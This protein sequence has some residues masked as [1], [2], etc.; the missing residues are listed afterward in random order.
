M[1]SSWLPNWYRVVFWNLCSYV[2]LNRLCSREPPLSSVDSFFRTCQTEMCGVSVNDF[3]KSESTYNDQ[4]M[5]L[6]CLLLDP[7]PYFAI[8]YMG[9]PYPIWLLTILKWGNWFT[10]NS[11]LLLCATTLAIPSSSCHQMWY[12]DN[13]FVGA[14]GRYKAT[15]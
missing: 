7:N 11:Q 2:S 10:I 6:G 8:C 13:R 3:L 5:W 14:K 9:I 1:G 4:V 12:S 15:K